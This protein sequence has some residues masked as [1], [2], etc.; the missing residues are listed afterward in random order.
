MEVH[1]DVGGVKVFY[2]TEG[3]GEPVILIHGNGLSHGQWKYNIGPLSKSHKVYTPDLPGFGL[4]D[5]PEVNYG[6][7]YYVEFLRSFIDALHIPT[8]VIVGHSMGGAVAAGLAARYPQEV[9]GLAI[10]N[11]T[12]I[13]P[14][15]KLYSKE[16]FDVFFSLSARSRKLFC[17][18]MFYDGLASSLLDDIMLVADNK[19]SRN[20][21]IKN[22]RDIMMYDSHRIS[23]L[24]SIAVPTL[25][26]WGLN[27]ML[28]PVSDAQKYHDLIPGSSLKVFDMCGH[29]PNVERYEEFN[30]TVNEFLSDRCHF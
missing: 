15:G 24:K 18:S 21:F 4:S 11:A 3:M 12:G 5:K 14:V 29:I 2:K 13:T 26:V 7:P 6:V 22:C 20:A 25:I 10:S 1:V 28:L 23:M 16:L 8:P 27:D 9:A 19:E 30:R 17:R